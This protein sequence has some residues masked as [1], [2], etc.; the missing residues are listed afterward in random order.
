MYGCLHGQF[1]SILFG[2]L[3]N[4]TMQKK[5]AVSLHASW[6]FLQQFIF[7]NL[8]SCENELLAKNVYSIFSRPPGSY[9]EKNK[10]HLKILFRIKQY[11]IEVFTS[12]VIIKKKCTCIITILRV[13]I[14]RK[15]VVFTS[16]QKHVTCRPGS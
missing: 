7:Q 11:H 9:F 2:R 4:W 8:S 5:H 16:V 3:Q 1:H 12:Q 6:T 14:Y 10:I 15:K 13:S